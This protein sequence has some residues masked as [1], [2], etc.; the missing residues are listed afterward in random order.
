MKKSRKVLSILLAMI[1]VLGAFPLAAFAAT[2]EIKL[3]E[4][5]TVNIPEDAYSE[6]VFTPEFDAHYVVYANGGYNEEHDCEIDP[7]ITVYNS[8]GEEVGYDDDCDYCGSY[9]SYCEFYANEGETYNIQLEEYDG[10]E[11]EYDVTVAIFGEIKLAPSDGAPYVE[12]TDGANVE[13]QWYK[14]LGSEELTDE[15]VTPC[16][17]DAQTATYDSENGWRGVL[18][19][20]D[21]RVDF[22]KTEI[23]AGQ[24]ISVTADCPVESLYI[25]C[26]CY[27][28]YGYWYNLE[29]GE[30][31]NYAVHH[32][33]T[34]KVLCYYYDDVPHVKAEITDTAKVSGGTESVLSS[35]EAGEYFCM[36]DYDNG[37]RYEFTD[38]VEHD[39]KDVVVPEKIRNAD[40]RLRRDIAGL[41]VEDYEEYIEILTDDLKFEDDYGDIAVYIDNGEDLDDDG[42]FVSGKTYNLYIYLAPESDK[43]LSN[44][45]TATVNG[46][47]VYCYTTS[48]EPGGE[49]GDIVVP[50]VTLEVEITVTDPCEHMCHQGGI[51]GFFWRIINLFNKIFGLNPFCECGATHY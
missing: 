44:N 35:S 34:Y 20:D 50:Y 4:T 3:D 23:D 26:E 5:K 27:E 6:L 43:L 15:N 33:C 32:E 49:Y 1:M 17:S 31:A 30:T 24:I 38:I 40:I 42:R 25:E 46:N 37:H 48:W 18:H 28:T 8:D 47:K 16:E 9:D 29:A 13:Y 36:L 12:V 19:A 11:V 51:V 41:N 10:Y 14:V 45:I 7:L 21:D 22:F 39:G 2:P